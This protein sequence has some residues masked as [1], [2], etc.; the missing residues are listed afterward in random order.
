M[1][2]CAP[3]Q[4]LYCLG[5]G[6]GLT[7]PGLWVTCCCGF[8]A[9]A[10]PPPQHPSLVCGWIL[11]RTPPPSVLSLYLLYNSHYDEE[12]LG[13][14][15]V[16]ARIQL[17]YCYGGFGFCHHAREESVFVNLLDVLFH[18]HY[19]NHW[20]Y[21]CITT[22]GAI[23]FLRIHVAIR[24]VALLLLYSIRGRKP[25]CTHIQIMQCFGACVWFCYRYQLYTGFETLY[26]SY[27]ISNHC[28]YV[29]KHYTTIPIIIV[30]RTH[31][32]IVCVLS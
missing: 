6:F 20:L 18:P 12:F 16:C 21:V 1:C 8:T 29:C 13:H 10:L 3:I 27:C 4:L 2:V 17:L 31:V 15:S 32:V 14:L 24:F 23:L 30:L 26:I 22:T 25:R 7:L 5:G 9:C 11:L 28:L 19:H